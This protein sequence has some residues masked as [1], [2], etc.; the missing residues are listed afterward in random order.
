MFVLLFKKNERDQLNI[1]K[2]TL[3]QTLD[4]ISNSR[5]EYSDN[6]DKNEIYNNRIGKKRIINSNIMS[7]KRKRKPKKKH[8]MSVFF[9]F[10]FVL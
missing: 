7:R 4:Q 3:I 6:S 10:C 2:R 5:T 8:V 9:F 1:Q